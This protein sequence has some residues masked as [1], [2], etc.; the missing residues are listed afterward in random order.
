MQRTALHNFTA[1]DHNGG[2]LMSLR[3]FHV[4][5]SF[6]DDEL[7]SRS[8]GFINNFVAGIWQVAEDQQET[9]QY[10]SKC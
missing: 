2:N 8:S 5:G 1:R 6:T 7:L 10:L 4:N 9:G 3:N